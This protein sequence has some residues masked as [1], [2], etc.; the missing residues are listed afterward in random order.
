VISFGNTQWY[1]SGALAGELVGLEECANDCWRVC[2]SMIPIG[3]LDVKRAAERRGLQF[4]W[5]IPLS[6]RTT[7]RRRRLYRR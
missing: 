1:V 2:F 6:A 3:M 4:G 7:K 5:L